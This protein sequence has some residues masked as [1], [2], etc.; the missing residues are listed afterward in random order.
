MVRGIK[1]VKFMVLPAPVPHRRGQIC[2]KI[3]STPTV[4]GYSHAFVI[5]LI[6]IAQFSYI[7]IPDSFNSLLFNLHKQFKTLS[8]GNSFYGTFHNV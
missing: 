1:I 6:F 3:F 5:I 4:V 2:K 7:Y 8:L